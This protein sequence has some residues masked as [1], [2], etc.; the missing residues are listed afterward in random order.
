MRRS[1]KALILQDLQ[2]KMVFIVGPRQ[3]G[4]TWLAKDIAA[5]YRN[6]L[7]LNFDAPDDA[8]LI[9]HRAWLAD[10]D[11]LVFDELHKMRDWKNYLKGVFD[12]RGNQH[13]LVTGSARLSTFSQAGDS[14]AGRY[15]AHRL[16][17]FDLA[18]AGRA[19]LDVTLE[20]LLTRGGFPEPL[21][22][23]SDVEA[24]RW[25][26][27][28]ADSLV[29]TDILDFE[30]VHDL[31]AIQTLLAMLRRRVGSPISY[32]SLAEDLQIAPN[33]VKKYI[34]IL[35]ALFIVFR[36]TPYARNI[37]RSLLKEPKL[38]FYD[39][40]MVVGDR[41][42]CL[43]NLVAVS[44]AKHLRGR[45]DASGKRLALHYLR[46]KEGKEVDFCLVEE[47]RIARM[48]EV[49]T[50]DP[51]PDPNLLFFQARYQFPATQ[52][53]EKLPREYRAGEVEV[54]NLGKYL[55]GL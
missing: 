32:K 42:A 54:R 3:V 7:Y 8:D 44:L 52:I 26:R 51:N 12:T 35:E 43:E 9:R 45:E 40:G 49:K 23:E 18:E 2:K 16:L 21:L 13:I 4:K 31:R 11:L 25:R 55:K 19:E 1:Q 41:G 5:G 46:T 20:R 14:L 48:I 10:V 22:A 34:Q 17:P 24:D 38:Y 37:A 30:R 47:E 6:P 28:Y 50:S 27:Q 53:V 29:R 33:T 36:V 39:Q 15:F